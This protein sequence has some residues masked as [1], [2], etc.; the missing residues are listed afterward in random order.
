MNKSL[1]ISFLGLFY[2]LIPTF[3]TA[4]D[5]NS[6]IKQAEQ[7]HRSLKDEEALEK[8]LEAVKLQPHNAPLLAK[9]SELYNLIGKRQKTKEQQ[10]TFYYKG[11]EYATEALRIAPDNAEAN[12]VM[13]MSMG[14]MAQMTSGEEK[15]KAVKDIKKYA[16]NCIKID[17]QNFKGY[18]VLGKWHYEVSS[19]NAVERLIVKIGYGAFPQSSMEDAAKNYQKSMQLYPDF[20]LN[21]LELAKAYKKLGDKSKARN[22]LLQLQQKPSITYDDPKIKGLGKELLDDL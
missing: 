18:H 7:L 13:A 10:K 6:L 11:K 17:P 4:Q 14:R 22:L 5:A 15:I 2:L 12:F 19:L 3:L 21:Y 20:L 16:D 9:V 8:Y 1:T